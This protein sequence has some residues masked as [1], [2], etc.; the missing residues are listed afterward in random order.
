MCQKANES[1]LLL[2]LHGLSPTIY[3]WHSTA[4]AAARDEGEEAEHE[5]NISHDDDDGE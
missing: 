3:P 2:G 4:A 5:R 1:L